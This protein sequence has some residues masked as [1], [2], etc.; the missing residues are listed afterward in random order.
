MSTSKLPCH[1]PPHQPCLLRL[2]RALPA[3]TALALFA[4]PATSQ[5]A[6][7]GTRVVQPGLFGPI[8]DRI[9]Q[10]AAAGDFD[11]DGY[12]DIAIGMPRGSVDGQERAGYV[13]VL[14]GSANGPALIG[15]AEAQTVHQGTPGMY[16]AVEQRDS[17]GHALAAGDFDGDGYDDLAIGVRREEYGGTGDEGLVNLAFGSK[18]GLVASS[19]RLEPIHVSS[20]NAYFGTTLA[21]GDFNTDGIDDLAVGAP[22]TD[23]PSGSSHGRVYHFYGG[24]DPL[25]SRYLLLTSGTGSPAFGTSLAVGDFNGDG[26]ADL[27]TGAPGG[28]S[29]DGVEGA[30]YIEVA[31]G[32]P[33]GLPERPNLNLDQSLSAVI[34]NDEPFDFFG[35]SLAAADF[36]GDG[37]DDLAVGLRGEDNVEG[38][39]VGEV[40]VFFGGGTSLSLTG[41]QVWRQQ[42]GINNLP[43]DN[44]RF[45]EVM[46]AG[47]IDGDGFGDL[48]LGSPFDNVG[49]FEDAGSVLVLYGA[50]A[51]LDSAGHQLF[52][53]NSTE[54]PGSV[55]EEGRFGAALALG[56]FDG[57]GPDLLVGRGALTTFG[58]TPNPILLTNVRSGP[59][60][61]GVRLNKDRF[62]MLV[63]WRDF[64]G[65]SGFGNPVQISDDSAVFYFFDT[66]NWELLIKVL[67]GCGLNNHF[68]TFFAATTN[69][70]FEVTVLDTQTGAVRVYDNPL[71]RS[72][73]AVTDTS[74]F[75]TCN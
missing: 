53:Q 70:Q 72:A 24:K 12:D 49:V 28:T 69:V 58:N 5:L 22:G 38:N 23:G 56:D 17:F 54:V 52:T 50:D 62:R 36:D 32:S 60:D 13:Q 26:Y 75:A 55:A 64:S 47:D 29:R 67:D 34:G 33:R 74:S 6:G 48:I 45:A 41:E 8:P 10:S 14:Y 16:G 43:Q 3:L 59:P 2:S 73:D 27:A 11:G 44:D 9:A 1:V 25:R 57:G 71:G 35:S 20:D 39:N 7:P 19:R 63:T 4:A 46:V 66:A 42:F 40:I 51:G 18:N 61:N 21:V 65:N 37:R 31:L 68:W 30:G 15:E